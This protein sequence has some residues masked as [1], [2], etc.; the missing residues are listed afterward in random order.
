[1]NIS[2]TDL[3]EC[4]AYHR[5]TEYV[6]DKR[7]IRAELERKSAEYLAMGG[8]IHYPESVALRAVKP[9]YE[10]EGG[11]TRRWEHDTRRVTKHGEGMSTWA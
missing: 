7:A 6:E 11:T 5:R 2:R 8:A 3:L 4:V 10:S 1:M 9:A